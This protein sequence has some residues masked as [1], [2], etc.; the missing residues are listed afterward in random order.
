MGESVKIVIPYS[1]IVDVE[2]STAM[3]FSETIEV[4]V[5]EKT[6]GFSVDSYFFAYFRDPGHALEQIRDV[7]RSYKQSSTGEGVGEVKDTTA[8]RSSGEHSRTPS[9]SEKTL[10]PGEHKASAFRFASLLRPFTVAQTAQRSEFPFSDSEP[11]V[12]SLSASPDELSSSVNTLTTR[13]Y[14]LP[15]ATPDAGF[16]TGR[17][18]VTSSPGTLS[19]IEDL[20]LSSDHTY[21]PPPSP[22][23]RPTV[24]SH[25][26][27]N[28][29]VPSWLRMPGRKVLS[30]INFLHSSSSD[31]VREVY[32]PG[33]SMD[34]SL[35]DSSHPHMEFS[36][37]D[38][39]E[40]PVDPEVVTKF[41]AS[42]AL[43]EK[44][45]L[46]SFFPGYLFRVLPVHGKFYISTSYL[47][48]RSSQPLVK[49]RMMI[50]I[51]D[52]LRPEPTKG[53]RFGMH[54]VVLTIKGHEELFFEFNSIARRDT[55]VEL[56][57]QQCETLR[58]RQLDGGHAS[59]SPAKR[60]ALFLEE[61]DVSK[62]LS[63]SDPDPILESQ[64]AESL[65]AVMFTSSSSTFLTFKPKESLH[66]TF[67]TIGSRGDVQPYI[68]LGKRL[69]QEGHRVRIA[70]HGEFKEWIE[71]HNI[72]YAYVG[73]DPAEL[74]RICVE[75]GMFT[76]S[77]L[78]EGATKFRGWI[79]DLLKTA[80]EAC[81]GTDVLVESPS[82]MGGI[83]IAEAL[84]IPY[85][86][87]F[88]MPWTRTR[89]YPHA[90]AVPEHKMGGAYNYMTYVM[91]D[92]VFWRGTSGQINRWRRKVLG[93]PSTNLDKLE[94]HKVPFLYNFSPA[95]VPPSLDWYEWIRVT[96]YWFLDDA[97]VGARKWTPPDG[98]V[99][100]IDSAHAAG[101]KVVYIGFGSIVV[102]DPGAMTKCVV[103]AILK[104]GV[105]AILSKGWSDRLA[106]KKPSA[107]QPKESYPPQ[108]YPISSI[109]HDWLFPP[110][111]P[112]I[113]KPFFG[114]QYFW[115]DRME[116]LGIGSCVRKLTIDHLTAALITATTD[117]RQ[118]SR[119]RA[120]G[121]TI[122]AEDGTGK[123]VESIYRDL[124]YA[125]SL[126]KR[127][128]DSDNEHNHH[129]LS[130]SPSRGAGGQSS[131][132]SAR[133]ASEDWSVI[134]EQD[135]HHRIPAHVDDHIEP[136]FTATPL[137]RI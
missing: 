116:A 135:D 14:S 36:M 108:I 60:E 57:E 21:P 24:E 34:Q 109:P 41:R 76:V 50:P 105:Y 94:Q 106:I 6:A 49:T 122:R 134:S 3:D 46:L 19:D 82:A 101:K 125:R 93:L 118:I 121:Q 72:E 48:F 35:D 56:V 58:E 80:W 97:D 137:Q 15:T 133:P 55:F 74:M 30:S 53:Y 100:F 31:R 120:I 92:Q 70:T 111:I 68:A 8:T 84:K 54:G 51:R 4:N 64:H 33:P 89:A 67:L 129:I 81:Q 62:S 110:G 29:G 130:R 12:A 131:S 98:L 40:A 28:V 27:W 10:S 104:S 7:V 112:T 103:E 102:S 18:E 96:G 26:S 37:I 128:D 44:E 75:N 126:I 119:A 2:K 23:S 107:D 78:K 45:I 90:F 65:P 39:K 16:I 99:E 9:H 88:T 85:F 13:A 52:I 38:A 1:L 113:I 77:F 95:V 132:S 123:A 91:F 47:C 127:G 136:P 20:S 42:F 66:F 86:R 25:G 83:H 61:L 71:S 117:E 115:A 87:A 114:D 17:R 43:D 124:E 22:G 69:L 73:G 59:P 11:V 5:M 32:S 79:D 63:E